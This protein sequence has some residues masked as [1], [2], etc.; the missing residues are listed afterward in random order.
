MSFHPK[1]HY[2]SLSILKNK[3]W[4]LKNTLDFLKYTDFSKLKTILFLKEI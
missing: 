3:L 4:K 2:L 1:G